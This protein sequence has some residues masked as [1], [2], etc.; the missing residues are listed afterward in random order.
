MGAQT[1][2][3]RGQWRPLRLSLVFLLLL[4]LALLGLGIASS[5]SPLRM[6]E[7]LQTFSDAW[8][9]LLA[10]TS[11]SSA[12]RQ[13]VGANAMTANVTQ[14]SRAPVPLAVSKAGEG[15][16]IAY[17]DHLKITF[18]ES[19]GVKVANGKANSD[20]VVA[21]VFPRMD[22]SAEYEV[23]ES[24][25][26]NIPKLGQVLATGQSIV[27]LQSTLA[28]AFERAIGRSSD[29]HV[30]IVGRQPIYVLGTVRNA[31]SFKFAPGMTVL[32]ALADA[33]GTGLGDT[34][35]AIEAT[36]ETERLRQAEDKMDRL[37]VKQAMLVARRENADHIVL[38]PSTRAQLSPTSAPE[39]LNALI[40]GAT[41]IL[42]S[43][44][45]GYQQQLVLA[46][47]QVDIARTEVEAQNMRANQLKDLLAKKQERLHGL[48]GIAA[49]GSVPRYKLTDV[50]A[51]ISELVARQEDLRV[52]LAQAERRLIEAEIAQAKIEHDY[53]AET[54]RDLATTQAAIDDTAR[55]IAS[56]QAVTEILGNGLPE[57]AGQSTGAQSLIITR[58]VGT[59]L[60]TIPA[61]DTTLLLPGDVLQVNSATARTPPASRS[62][63]R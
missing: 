31:G 45:K 19:V 6:T 35:R 32:Q 62:T 40:A 39:R 36:R 20:R 13:S 54:E 8:T 53:P 22:L 37:L 12:P 44:R 63:A 60:T 46:Q 51:D 30:A 11:L 48:E 52:T 15:D 17:G 41:A 26:V 43:E 59:G 27:A 33:G 55:A 5:L 14:T 23:D 9:R 18:Y 61:V 28:A 3:G 58:R 56:M 29:V 4:S 34:S 10:A 16:V 47:R 42:T 50:G 24:G 38:T 1:A 2:D 49:N 57:T 25:G 21:A 7:T